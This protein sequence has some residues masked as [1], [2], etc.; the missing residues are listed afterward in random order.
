[1]YSG[2]VYYYEEDNLK[3]RAS[4]ARYKF[5]APFTKEKIVLDTGCGARQGPYL[6]AESALKVFGLDISY[7]AI[8]YCSKHWQKDN[9]DYIVAD[10]KA[11]PFKDERLDVILSLEVIEHI[12][13][14]KAYL[15][16]MLRLLRQKGILI[17]ST[18]QRSIASPRGELSNPDH[19]REFEL[20]EFD[21]ILRNNFTKVTMYGHFFST[22]VKQIEELRKA[23]IKNFSKIPKFIKNFIPANWKEYILRK[24]HYFSIMIFKGLSAGMITEKDSIFKN[25]DLK[26]ATHLLAI[27]EK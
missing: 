18:P 16:E 23:N 17:I 12:D 3:I 14:Y 27:C 2:R 11:L 13:D 15:L 24:Y 10:V 22:R 19:V 26:Q 20:E 1:M 8:D 5:C 7:A 25:E 6:I 4:T 9:V 21:S